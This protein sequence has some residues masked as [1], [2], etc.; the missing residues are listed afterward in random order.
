MDFISEE[1][2]QWIGNQDESNKYIIGVTIEIFGSK[3]DTEEHIKIGELT[4]DFFESESVRNIGFQEL[5]DMVSTD[6]E[7]MASAITNNGNIKDEICDFDENLMYIDRIFID[8]KYRGMG[9]AGYIISNLKK[10][11]EYSVNLNP[12]VLIL[13]PNPQEKDKEGMLH[14]TENTAEKE[15]NKQKLIDLYKKLG[16]IEIENTN[17]MIKRTLGSF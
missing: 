17:Y 16:F 8:E 14:E 10:I 2:E 6:L 5:C 4:G 1:I 9:I 3:I 12:H 13:L 15:A 7:H 11:L